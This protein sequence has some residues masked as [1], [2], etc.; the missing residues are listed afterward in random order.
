ML[1]QSVSV[2]FLGLAVAFASSANVHAQGACGGS[3]TDW[4]SGNTT[5]QVEYPNAQGTLVVATI[6]LGAIAS[7]GT[8]PATITPAQQNGA[9][10]GNYIL[11]GAG[12]LAV[13]FA[14]G[15]AGANPLNFNFNGQVCTAGGTT[16]TG[17]S[18]VAIVYST[19]AG[20]SPVGNGVAI[21]LTP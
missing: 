5:W 3:I 10:A 2:T 13:S 4:S 6:V 21:R 16:V 15:G 1:R 14:S 19:P 11:S 20:L 12:Y 8:S 7:G 9:T 17:A 18:N